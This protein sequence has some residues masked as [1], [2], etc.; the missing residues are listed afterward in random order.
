MQ[1]LTAALHK[2]CAFAARLLPWRLSDLYQIRLTC[3]VCAST[4]AYIH[5]TLP[6]TFGLPHTRSILSPHTQRHWAPSNSRTFALICSTN[7]HPY[8]KLC[9]TATQR[10]EHLSLRGKARQNCMGVRATRAKCEIVW[11]R[12]CRAVNSHTQTS[13]CGT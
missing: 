3:R 1:A 8:I 6:T 11:I 4:M 12:V 9:T 2:L 5:L 7:S 10:A 13:M